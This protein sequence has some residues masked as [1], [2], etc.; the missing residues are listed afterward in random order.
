MSI[1]WMAP[2]ALIGLALVT[3]PIAIHLLV[4]QHARRLA[5]PSLRFVR[6]T[7][8]AAQRYR[9]PQDVALLACR[10]AIVVAAALALAGPILQSR[11]RAAGYAQRMSR[12]VVAVDRADDRAI[13]TIA[14]GAFRTATFKRA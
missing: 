11:S 10:I 8:L 5:Y 7:Q 1:A 12:A 14:S 3:L 9:N 2:A 6:E 13:A 4:R